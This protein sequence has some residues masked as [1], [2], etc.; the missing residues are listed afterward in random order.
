M[1]GFIR[2]LWCDS[3]SDVAPGVLLLNL[4]PPMIPQSDP[5]TVL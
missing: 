2:H 3:V 5:S 4:I 1:F